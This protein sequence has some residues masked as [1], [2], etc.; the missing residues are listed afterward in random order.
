MATDRQVIGAVGRLA[1][2]KGFEILI[3]AVDQLLRQEFNI[4]LWI[5]GDGPD[6][7]RLEALIAELGCTDCIRL[8]G[9]RTDV[10]ELYE[11]MDVFALSSF[12]EGL[13]NVLLEAMALG[14]PVVATRVNSVPQ[15]ITD[16]LNGLLI[17]PGSADELSAAL[18]RLLSDNELRQRLQG[19]ARQKVEAC[20]SFAARMRKIKAIYDDVLAIGPRGQGRIHEARQS[21]RVLAQEMLSKVGTG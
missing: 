13:P 1:E 6:R 16:G 20:Y 15:A 2:E 12:R 3:R 21:A 8:L 14:L 11:A 9:H 19:K 18:A 5:V 7:P 17:E 10:R 4:E